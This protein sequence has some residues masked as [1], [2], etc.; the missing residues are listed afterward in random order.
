MQLGHS[1][2]VL[3]TIM[4]QCLH[5]STVEGIVSSETCSKML[6]TYDLDNQ[7]IIMRLSQLLVRA[8][9]DFLIDP[10]R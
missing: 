3:E 2:W 1:Y 4:L 5:C 7:G 9:I 10:I 8:T 6:N